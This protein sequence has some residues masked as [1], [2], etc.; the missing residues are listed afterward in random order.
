MIIIVSFYFPLLHY[1]KNAPQCVR[2]SC[3]FTLSGTLTQSIMSIYTQKAVDTFDKAVKL[4]ESVSR[5][6]QTKSETID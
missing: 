2:G 4:F 6:I 5:I 1:I 3:G